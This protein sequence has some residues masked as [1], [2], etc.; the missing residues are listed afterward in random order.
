MSASSSDYQAPLLP[1]EYSVLPTFPPSWGDLNHSQSDDA[2]LRPRHVNRTLSRN[3]LQS[4][5]IYL[6]DFISTD[7]APTPVGEIITGNQPPLNYDF[8]TEA[9]S[10]EA[11]PFVLLASLRATFLNPQFLNV[12]QRFNYEIMNI[13]NPPPLDRLVQDHEGRQS[14]RIPDTSDSPSPLSYRSGSTD[15]QQFM[16][17]RLKRAM[18]IDK[19]DILMSTVAASTRT[20][21]K[22][23][24]IR[25]RSSVMGWR[26]LRI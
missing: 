3:P 1:R 15:P 12:E 10:P 14:T 9:Y 8:T 20:R 2:I 21:Y 18:S 7:T 4:R 26:S 5:A 23:G 17:N 25:G 19:I 6:G 13:L 11:R 16:D 24:R 22:S